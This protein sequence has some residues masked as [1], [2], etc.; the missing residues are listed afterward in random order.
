MSCERTHGYYPMGKAT[1]E[2]VAGGVEREAV[3]VISFDGE[4]VLQVVPP[5]PILHPDVGA[6]A[7]LTNVSVEVGPGGVQRD[8]PPQAG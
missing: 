7:G 2:V 4:V 1:E 3:G 5:P 6:A 8:Q